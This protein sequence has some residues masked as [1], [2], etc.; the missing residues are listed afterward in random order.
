M[1]DRTPHELPIARREDPHQLLDRLLEH[2]GTYG[3]DVATSPIHELAPRAELIDSVRELHAAIAELEHTI[4]LAWGLVANAGDG[5]W[6]RESD[7]WREA[8]ARWRDERYTRS[9]S[10]PAADA[11]AAKVDRMI[12][13]IALAANLARELWGPA[14]VT[15]VGEGDPHQ[16]SEGELSIEVHRGGDRFLDERGR[17]RGLDEVGELPAI[18][19]PRDTYLGE[20]GKVADA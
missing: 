9:S 6:T 12:G 15:V 8:A 20:Q 19:R 18:Q 5:D 13:A 1:P 4:D 7:Q 17:E 16:A 11:K 14:A 2:V 3:T 10:A